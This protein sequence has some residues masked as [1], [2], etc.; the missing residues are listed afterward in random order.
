MAGILCRGKEAGGRQKYL[1]SSATILGFTITWR[2]VE[3]AAPVTHK[4]VGARHGI[5]PY[6]RGHRGLITATTTALSATK[7]SSKLLSLLTF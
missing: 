3:A 7:S 6:G 5:T 1:I 2:T 4:S